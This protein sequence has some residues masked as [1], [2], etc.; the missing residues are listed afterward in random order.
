MRVYSVKAS[1]RAVWLA[2]IKSDLQYKVRKYF[3][4]NERNKNKRKSPVGA[5]APTGLLDS[6]TY[7]RKE[8]NTG[9]TQRNIG[10]DYGILQGQS[11]ISGGAKFAPPDWLCGGMVSAE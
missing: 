1:V 7:Y 11:E 4:L 6:K 9:W 5:N 10:T 2:D 3:G 8:Q